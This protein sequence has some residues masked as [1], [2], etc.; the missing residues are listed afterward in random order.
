MNDKNIS[1][2]NNDIKADQAP[3]IATPQMQQAARS[4]YP[5]AERYNRNQIEFALD[6]QTKKLSKQL[7]AIIFLLIL[8]YILGLL[9]LGFVFYSVHNFNK[10]VDSLTSPRYQLNR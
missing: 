10:S 3:Q 9:W 5:D 7:S 8:P 2:L 6:K 4:V 1:P